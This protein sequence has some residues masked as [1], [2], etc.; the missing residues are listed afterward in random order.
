MELLN[1]KNKNSFRNNYYLFYTGAFLLCALCLTLY[2]LVQGKTNIN[3]VNDGMNQHFRGMLY[4]SD[5]LQDFL[6]NFLNNHEIQPL[7]WDFSIGE[8]SDIFTTL[9]C[10]SFADPLC[11]INVFVPDQYM[12][13]AYLFSSVFRLYLAGLFFSM[14]CFYLNVENKFSIFFLF[15]GIK[16]LH[17]AHFFFVGFNVSSTSYFRNRKNNKWR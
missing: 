14:L 13:L 2:L 4:Y 15:L 11:L 1:K 16:K 9:H 8:G 12:H 7:M 17:H 3:Y 6:Y 10:Y 5:Y